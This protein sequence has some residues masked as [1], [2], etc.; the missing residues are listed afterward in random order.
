MKARW[1]VLGVLLL[2]LLAAARAQDNLDSLFGV[3]NADIFA[4]NAY[5][6]FPWSGGRTFK[7][8]R[9]LRA[10]APGVVVPENGTGSVN[11]SLVLLA[12]DADNDNEV[13]LFDFGLLV[14]AFGALR[15]DANWNQA[16][17]FDGDEE[18]TLFDFG[19][20]VQNFGMVGED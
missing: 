19:I 4:T 2:L 12:G 13:T 16:V 1:L 10:L 18:I 17:D 3:K 14:Q 8:T 9:S 11:L 20:L 5:L 15:G 7:F 6:F